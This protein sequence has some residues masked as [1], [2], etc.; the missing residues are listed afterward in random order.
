MT[1]AAAQ[2]AQSSSTSRRALDAAAAAHQIAIPIHVEP[3]D[4]VRDGAGRHNRLRRLGRGDG[5][6]AAAACVAI[7]LVRFSVGCVGEDEIRKPVAIVVC[8]ASAEREG[9]RGSFSSA[10]RGD[11]EAAGQVRCDR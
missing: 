1:T 3:D 11:G 4:R 10:S 7:E 9:T 5:D 8:V 2:Q 6:E